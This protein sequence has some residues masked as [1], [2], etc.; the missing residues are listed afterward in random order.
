[1]TTTASRATEVRAAQHFKWEDYRRTINWGLMEAQRFGL[2]RGVHAPMDSSDL[3]SRVL[4]L[5]AGQASP[6]HRVA[7]DIVGV[8]LAGEID[9]IVG[10]QRFAL[11]ECDLLEVGADVPRSYFNPGLTDALLFVAAA[12][13]QQGDRHQ[14]SYQLEQDEPGWEPASDPQVRHV[15]LADYRRR[16]IYRGGMVQTYGFHRGVMPH[17]QGEALRGHVVRVPAGQGSPW[18]SVGGDVT[19]VGMVGEIE[20]YAES[21]AFALGPRDVLVLPPPVYALQNVGLT[22]GMYFSINAKPASPPKIAYFDSAVLG[23]PLAGPGD[24]MTP[25]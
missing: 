24:E 8:A 6:V 13:P 17:V 23:D 19:F 15:P 9:C 16:V 5:P 11:K 21:Q 22:D 4:R 20:V 14:V 1:M 25:K 7:A 10:E 12:R 3:E 2:H 18:H